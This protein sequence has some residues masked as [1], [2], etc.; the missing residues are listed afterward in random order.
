MSPSVKNGL[1]WWNGGPHA[2]LCADLAKPIIF[3]TID[4]CIILGLFKVMF[5]FPNGTSTMAGES[6]VKMFYFL[7]TP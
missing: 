1:G 3:T 4:S 7:G 2:D 5:Y 6:I